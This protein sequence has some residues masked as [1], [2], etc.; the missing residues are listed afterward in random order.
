MKLSIFI[1]T[2][3]ILSFTAACDVQSGI[4]KKS[5]EKFEPSPTP[6][7]VKAT[8]EPPIDP[9]DIVSVDTSTPGPVLS[10]NRSADKKPVDC[11]KFNN[12]N[13]NA[14]QQEVVIKGACNKL[15]INGDGN[16]ITGV[17]FNEIIINGTDNNIEHTK[18]L[19]GR[20]PV[21]ADNASGNTVSK[22]AAVEDKKTRKD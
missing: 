7:I 16:R 14:D 19:N 12:V 10:V 1:T 3:L 21:V 8:P 6:T 20:R 22:I 2:A 17:A 15:M 4:T 13:V 18:Y 11:A 5:V 9:A